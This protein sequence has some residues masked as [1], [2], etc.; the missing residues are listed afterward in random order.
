MRDVPPQTALIAFLQAKDA[1]YYGKVCELRESVRGWL[2]YIPHTFPHYTRHTLE[3]SD[4]IV[5]QMSKLLFQDDHPESHVID[6]SPAEAYIL[7]AAAYLHDAGMVTS[8]SQKQE[9][10]ASDAWKNWTT[11]GP[12]A[13]RWQAVQAHASRRLD[14]PNVGEATGD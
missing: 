4:E 9:I 1:A 14:N 5:L 3:H 13:N 12:G 6:L 2:N 8:D 7:I 11:D 10:L